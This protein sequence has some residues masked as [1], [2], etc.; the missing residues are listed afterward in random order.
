MAHTLLLQK[1]FGNDVSV[2]FFGP[3]V[4]KKIESDRYGNN[5]NLSLT[6]QDLSNLLKS[7]NINFNDFTNEDEKFVP[8]KAE[9]GSLYPIV[10]GMINTMGINEKASGIETLSISGLPHLKYYLDGLV[11]PKQI[12]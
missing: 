10:G 9:E 5:L 1:E 2:V 4:A 3:C 6:F 7:H 8:C 11:V 12:G